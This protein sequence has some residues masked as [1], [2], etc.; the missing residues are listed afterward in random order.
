MNHKFLRAYQKFDMDEVKSHLL[1][2]GELSAHC[3]QCNTLG[4]KFDTSRCPQ[5]QAEFKYI[6]FRN[7]KENMPKIQKLNETNPRLTFVDYDDFKRI[8][9]RLKAQEFFK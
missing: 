4:L 5:C 3:A 1:I 7:I 8:T 6:T 9:G 2:C